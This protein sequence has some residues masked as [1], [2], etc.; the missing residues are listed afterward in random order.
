MNH[1]HVLLSAQEPYAIS[2]MMQ[3]L[4]R[5][6]VKYFNTTYRLRKSYPVYF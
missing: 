1:V 4:G 5:R 6:F 2:R 3:H